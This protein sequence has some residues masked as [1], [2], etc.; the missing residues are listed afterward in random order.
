MSAVCAASLGLA[1]A[2][3]PIRVSDSAPTGAAPER[4]RVRV[5]HAIARSC[6]A[7]IDS[8]RT[9]VTIGKNCQIRVFAGQYGFSP[10]APTQVRA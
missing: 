6:N 5:A 9:S 10:V 8:A 3:V 4:L 7:Q 1:V 2:E